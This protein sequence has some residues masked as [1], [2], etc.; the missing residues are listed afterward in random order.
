MLMVAS[1]IPGPVSRK[2]IRAV[3][4]LS[5]GEHQESELNF[6]TITIYIHQISGLIMYP[7]SL[8]W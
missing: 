6:R 2:M 3:I 7:L 4:R 1:W 8:S 5:D